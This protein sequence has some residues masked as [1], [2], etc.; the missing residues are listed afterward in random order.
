M[1]SLIEK[2]IAHNNFGKQLGM[3]FNIITD[4]EIEY[5]LK[6]TNDHLATPLSAH[7]GVISALADAL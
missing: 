1:N 7:G 3:H 2:Y 4:G 5:H 6:I